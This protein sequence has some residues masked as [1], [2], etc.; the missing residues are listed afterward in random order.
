MSP[1][2]KE[3]FP[4][5]GAVERTGCS[6]TEAVPTSRAAKDC[7]VRDGQ[8][9]EFVDKELTVLQLPAVLFIT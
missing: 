6:N 7:C 3:S 8:K 2:G 9:L 4:S 1:K 5:L